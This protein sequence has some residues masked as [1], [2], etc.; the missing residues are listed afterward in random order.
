MNK[1]FFIFAF[2]ISM[3]YL[4]TS[5]MF[6]H[7]VALATKALK[8]N[9]N[10][11][12]SCKQLDNH[13]HLFSTL[14]KKKKKSKDPFVNKQ[15]TNTKSPEVNSKLSNHLT[16]SSASYADKITAITKTCTEKMHSLFII[17]SNLQ[18]SISGEEQR[19]NEELYGENV[20]ETFPRLV[21]KKLTFLTD[22]ELANEYGRVDKIINNNLVKGIISASISG[23]MLYFTSNSTCELLG[24][25]GL[26]CAPNY[27]A[28]RSY[29]KYKYREALWS[30]AV[31][32]K[33]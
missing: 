32:R 16:F 31:H 7:E 5:A 1:Q 17:C 12:I 33:Y 26:L 21:K 20:I 30:E 28:L 8:A 6:K 25:C 18:K 27:Y 13:T 2:L 14:Q 29:K 23:A 3:F 11:F 9:K 10:Q 24:M 4:Q 15:K 19:N 22:E